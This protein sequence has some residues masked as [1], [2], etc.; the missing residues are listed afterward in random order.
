MAL[1]AA[2]SLGKR[3]IDIVGADCVE[4]TLLKFSKFVKKHENYFNYEKDENKF[5]TDL[6]SIIKKHKP[7]EDIPYVLMPIFTETPIIAK[8]KERLS[9]IITVATPDYNDMKKVHPKTN[10]ADT[11]KQSGANIPYTLSV[12]NKQELEE[13]IGDAMETAFRKL[14]Y[15]NPKS[16][17]IMFNML[18]I[19]IINQMQGEDKITRKEIVEFVKSK[20]NL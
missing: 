7:D 8:N 3:K 13:K 1:V 16:V 11:A 20:Y 2:H 15:E 17:R 4:T 19:S 5:L 14:G 9:N 12:K 10:L 18:F 6:E